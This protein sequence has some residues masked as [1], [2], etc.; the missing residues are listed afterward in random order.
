MICCIGTGK[1]TD[2]KVDELLDS[3]RELAKNNE[4][5]KAW[6]D[7]FERYVDVFRAQVQKFPLQN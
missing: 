4:S 3:V 6:I 2:Y 1:K 5:K 7:T